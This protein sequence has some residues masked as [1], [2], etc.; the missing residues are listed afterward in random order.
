MERKTITLNLNV[1]KILPD[2]LWVLKARSNDANRYVLKY[3]NIDDT[4]YCC[5]DSRRVHFCKSKENLPQGLENGLYDVIIAKDIIIFNPA[6]GTFPDYKSV[7]P[8]DSEKVLKVHLLKPNMADLS[9]AI[10]NIAIKTQESKAGVNIEFVKDLSG[11]SW[12]VMGN[13]EGKPIKCIS[14][15]LLAILMPLRI[16]KE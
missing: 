5:T 4:G 16:N 13:G 10:I 6:E 9:I 12:D 14:D 8:A 1:K 7:I 15:N 11:Y 2:L 3:L